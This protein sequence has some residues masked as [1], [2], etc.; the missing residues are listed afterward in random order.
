MCIRDRF[1][2]GVK[3]WQ[4]KR[5]MWNTFNFGGTNTTSEDQLKVDIGGYNSLLGKSYGEMGGEARTMHK[6]QGEG[7]PRRRGQSFEYFVTTSGEPAKTEIMDG[8]ISDWKRINGG[9][10]CLLY[11]SP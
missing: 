6:S 9:D 1:K 5:I 11:T 2:Y 10:A 3:P 4:A 8:V 7:R